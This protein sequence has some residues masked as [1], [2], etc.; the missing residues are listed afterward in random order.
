MPDK[1]TDEEIIALYKDGYEE[2]LKELIEKY[3]SPVFNFVAQ[4]AGRENATD[5]VQEIFIKVWKNLKRF[6]PEK[7]SF[8]TWIFTIA[9]NASIDFL[10][11]KK[12]ILFSDLGNEEIP[13]F[14]ENIPDEE[15]LP[16]QALQKLQD[17]NLLNK[18]LEELSISYRTVLLLHYQEEMTFEEIGK[19]LKKPLNTV[20]SSHYRAILKLRKKLP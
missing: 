11:K 6:D 15:L 3:T 12:N 14:S 18:L 10:K 9:K 7:A 13:D 19:V 20:K 17:S 16:D 1:K 4:L 5:L 8:K 2:V